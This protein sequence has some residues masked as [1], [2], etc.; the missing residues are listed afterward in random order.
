M[1]LDTLWWPAA[2]LGEALELLAVRAG[3]S[4][5]AARTLGAPPPGS[6]TARWLPWA[7]AQLGIEV[8]AVD[9]SVPELPELLRGAGPALLPFDDATRGA[10]FFVL[11]G[12]RRG[13]AR[14][15]GPDLKPGRCPLQALG[16]AL[17]Q[18]HEAALRPELDALIDAAQVP[19][20]R[21]A[22]VRAALLRERLASERIEP[23]WMLRLPASA[24]F[25]QQLSAA[26]LPLRLLQALLAFALLYGLEVAGWRLIGDAALGGRLDL[27]WMAAWLLMLLS[28][29]PLRLLGGWLQSSFALDAGRLLKSR[30]LAGA[31]R[32]D[33]QQVRQQGVGHLLGRVIESQALESLA[34]SGGLA[35]GVALLELV[36]AA[37]ILAQGAAAMGHLLLLPAWLAV[38]GALAWRQGR[39]LRDWTAA[40]LD[41]THEL[42]ERMVGHRTRL[43]QERPTQRDA[44]EDRTM[45]AYLGRAQ[46]MDRAAAPVFVG[47]PTGWLWL[48]IA[49]L[50]P[51][52]V[53]GAAPAALAI[54]LGGILFAQRAFAGIAGGLAGLL[55][56]GIAWRQVAELFVAG[57]AEPAPAFVPARPASRGDSPVIEASALGFR[58]R[59]EGEPVLTHA[60]LCI[61]PGER[62]LLEG[63]SG[64]GKSTLAALLTGL[65]QPQSGLLLLD[66]WD[67]HTLGDDWHRLATS[68]PQFHENHVLS[69]TLAFNLLMGR[70]WPPSL[71][72]LAEAEALCH[73]LGL[74][75]L[76]ARMP[77][78]LMQRVGETGWQ[79]SHGERSRIFLARALLQR[80]PLTVMDESFAALD[81]ETLAICLRCTL[82]RTDA[83]VVIAHP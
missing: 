56:A 26:G 66:G 77:S 74:G 64:A 38:T 4:S 54:S 55:R 51:A 71:A 41:L 49:A 1:A 32:L 2:R 82:A 67:R 46:A 34:L 29:V 78:G 28:L 60:D 80:A 72:S 39:R 9:A 3:L 10:G 23:C 30:L 5:G 36:I 20:A 52:F 44:H 40:R 21:R 42:I 13:Q 81:P 37:W 59:P 73:E 33:V 70:E 45:Q 69:G 48:G 17:C 8:Q 43:A 24:D 7:A 15:L 12:Q 53:D 61:R 83:L 79:L 75:E 50:A 57:R 14:L 18:R 31:L 68:A 27:G 35:V 47:V 19:A 76:L 62:V 25:R 22:D 6:E 11:L 58:H 16:A 63:R 65:R